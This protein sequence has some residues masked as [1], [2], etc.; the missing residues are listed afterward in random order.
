MKRF[1]SA[2]HAQRFLSTHSP[3]HNHFQLRRHRLSA[4]EHRAARA[5]AFTTW[6]EATGMAR[7]G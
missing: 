6:R 4:T 1:K 7:V 2:R 3:I 5:R